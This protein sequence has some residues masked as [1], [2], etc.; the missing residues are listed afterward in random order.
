MTVKSEICFG[1]TGE[2]LS[3]YRSEFDARRAADHANRAYGNTLAPYQCPKCRMW[4]LSPKERH[5][6]SSNH[7]NCRDGNGSSKDLYDTKNGAEKRAGILSR[8]KH[9]AL[10]VY[11]CPYGSGFHLTKK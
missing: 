4:H 7:C 1:R 8:E 6:P 2:P 3:E 10:A 5:T 9:I 11:R